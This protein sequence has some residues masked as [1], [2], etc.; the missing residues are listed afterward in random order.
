MKVIVDYGLGNPNSVK[1][2]IK[3][4][5]GS[6]IVSNEVEKIQSVTALTNV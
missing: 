1:N 2:I 3:K 5:G 4:V 6:A